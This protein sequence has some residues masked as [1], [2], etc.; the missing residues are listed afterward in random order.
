MPLEAKIEAILPLLEAHEVT[1]CEDVQ[2]HYNYWRD[3]VNPNKD[4][5]CNLRKGCGKPTLKT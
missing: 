2:E 4:D 3:N 5:C 1:V